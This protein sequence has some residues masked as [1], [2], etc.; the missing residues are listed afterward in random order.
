MAEIQADMSKK[1]TPPPMRQKSRCIYC[2]VQ[3][4]FPN[5]CACRRPHRRVESLIVR[6]AE[7]QR[8]PSRAQRQG[9]ER[10]SSCK[11]R[12]SVVASN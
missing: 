6:R 8:R 1:G 5:V 9:Q 10:V 7:W 12:W 3:L 11:K 2:A 4:Q